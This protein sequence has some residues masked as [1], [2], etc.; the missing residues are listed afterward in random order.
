MA[1]KQD[2]TKTI[3][4]AIKQAEAGTLTK[5]LIVTDTLFVGHARGARLYCR[6]SPKGK[7]TWA[8]RTPRTMIDG[9]RVANGGGK[10]GLFGDSRD[11]NFFGVE[12]ARTAAANWGATMTL[13]GTD[14]VADTRALRDTMTLGELAQAYVV[15]DGSSM[16]SAAS[17]LSLFRTHFGDWADTPIGMIT[18]ED[19]R[20]RI[21]AKSK[22]HANA[23]VK[24]QKTLSAIYGWAATDR[25]I[26]FTGRSPVSGIVLA[27]H[28]PTV[29]TVTD[30]DTGA[31]WNGIQAARGG[32]DEDALDIIEL[33]LLQARRRSEIEKLRWD[34]VVENDEG[35]LELVYNWDD[36]KAGKASKPNDKLV[37]PVT[38]RARIIL[39]RRRAAAHADARFVFTQ[40]DRTKHIAVSTVQR[41][42]AQPKRVGAV[43]LRTLMPG[44]DID[45]NCITL[46]TLRDFAGAALADMPNVEVSTI[47]FVLGHTTIAIGN[48]G[49]LNTMTRKYIRAPL[50][51]I[52]AALELWNDHIEGVAGTATESNII[53]G[54]WSA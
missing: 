28:V 11:G 9:K 34:M 53:N 2:I 25:Q 52:R 10:I 24:M 47:S 42:Y 17:W 7:A 51:K 27:K 22:K 19:C 36:H 33:I 35:D 1:R 6:V 18:Y 48:G 14:T 29:L 50:E 3:R 31:I 15:R 4:A 23:A 45:T 44:F 20:E 13:D 12:E 26:N 41:V 49:S 21:I 38:R 16:K 5:E 39:D 37:I 30:A 46:H 32:S 40:K 54:N 8:V 43:A